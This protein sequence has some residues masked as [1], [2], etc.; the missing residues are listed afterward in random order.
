MSRLKSC[1]PRVFKYLQSLGKGETVA[2]GAIAKRFGLKNPRH[3]GWI[4]RQ[5]DRPDAVPCFK[6]V[7]A[8]GT[9]A[10]GYKFGGLAAQKKR[11]VAE[12]IKFSNDK[13]IR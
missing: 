9:L 6:V 11:L 8:D 4:L 1:V 5:N 13:I 2:Y 3:V 10:Q 12:G 7:R